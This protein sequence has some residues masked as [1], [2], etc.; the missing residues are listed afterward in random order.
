LLPVRVLLPV[1]WQ[2][3]GMAKLL[4]RGSNERG[5]IPAEGFRGKWKKKRGV[6]QETDDA[7]RG[8]H[9]GTGS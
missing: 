5:S 6:L 3:L 8:S 7:R 1:K 9:K 2:T 4:K